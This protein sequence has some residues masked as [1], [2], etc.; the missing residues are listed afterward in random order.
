M[1]KR[2]FSEEGQEQVVVK[3]HRVNCNRK[4]IVGRRKQMC[5]DPNGSSVCGRCPN[6]CQD[7]R[8]QI[9]S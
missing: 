5:N 1:Y 2:E 7:G 8:C 6:H 4:V 9:H 3:P